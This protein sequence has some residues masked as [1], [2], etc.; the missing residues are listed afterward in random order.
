MEDEAP[1]VTRA[2]LRAILRETAR[3]SLPSAGHA[4]RVA[5]LAWTF[6]RGRSYRTVEPRTRE[7]HAPDPAQ[8]HAAFARIGVEATV[9]ALGAWLAEPPVGTAPRRLAVVP[10]RRPVRLAH[11]FHDTTLPFSDVPITGGE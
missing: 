5:I 3:S 9:E 8:L 1:P 6:V 2:R 7:R 10:P 11:I 4:H